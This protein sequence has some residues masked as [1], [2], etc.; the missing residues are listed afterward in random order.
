[1]KDILESFIPDPELDSWNEEKDNNNLSWSVIKFA[2]TVI[3][4]ILV[5]FYITSL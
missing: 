2:A 3:T 5:M 4:L 1:M